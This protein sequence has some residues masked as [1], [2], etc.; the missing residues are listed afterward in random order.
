MGYAKIVSWID[1]IH[2][3]LTSRIEFDGAIIIHEH[4]KWN[5]YFINMNNI[6]LDICKCYRKIDKFYLIFTH[7]YF[8][9]G[10]LGVP[11]EKL[12]QLNLGVGVVSMIL[13]IFWSSSGVHFFKRSRLLTA[14]SICS[15]RLAPVIAVETLGFLKVQANANWAKFPPSYWLMIWSSFKAATVFGVL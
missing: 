11:W 5:K 8:N 7:H 1:E 12:T 14:S 15:S 3:V 13:L 10:L 9:S 2:I 6:G 4:E